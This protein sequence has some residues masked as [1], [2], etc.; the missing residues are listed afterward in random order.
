MHFLLGEQLISHCVEAINEVVL[1]AP[2]VKE[3]VL[4]RLL[5]CISHEV[6]VK[7]VTR[8]NPYEIQVGVS[9]LSI[10]PLIRA[11]ENTSLFLCSNLH[12]KYF[13]IDGRCLVGSA[14]M[15]GKALGWN[16][17][18]NL[19]LLVSIEYQS[20]NLPGF[21]QELFANSVIVDE[22]V[23]QHTKEAVAALPILIGSIENEKQELAEVEIA[24]SIQMLPAYWLPAT[25]FPENLYKAYCGK[26][27]ELT[28]ASKASTESD[29]SFLSI[30][31]GLSNTAFNLLV[32]AMLLQSPI[33]SKIDSFLTLP[34]R[35]GAVTTFMKALPCADIPDFEASHSW[36]TLIRWFIL[37]LPNRYSRVQSPYSEVLVKNEQTE[38]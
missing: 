29:L 15:T 21:E 27:D 11:R 37:F 9:D 26:Q 36:Q 5:D 32:G 24:E 4:K 30:P 2:F 14:N 1:V 31:P 13:R 38:K 19:E 28:G 20:Q 6:R 33:V 10:W 7:V 22:F 25:R 8:W 18:P 3:H 12:A 17:T 23:Y 34:R 35:F 16:K